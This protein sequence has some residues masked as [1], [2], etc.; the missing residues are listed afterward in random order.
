MIANLEVALVNFG[1]IV[2]RWPVCGDGCNFEG[3]EKRGR[4]RERESEQNDANKTEIIILQ[5]III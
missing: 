5:P 4:D 3:N 2:N 1:K